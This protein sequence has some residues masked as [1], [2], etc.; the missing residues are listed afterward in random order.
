MTAP[1]V[2]IVTGAARGIGA[3][4]A[5]AL[6]AAGFELVLVDA[7][8]DDERLGYPLATE[9][10]LQAVADEVGAHTVV[11]DAADNAVL[12][13]AVEAA[14]RA[15]QLTAAVAA[16]GVISGE[17]AAWDV[18]DD[19]WTVLHETNV[20]AVQRL[21]SATI[22]TML[23]H[24]EPRSGRFIAIGSPI[25]HKATPR[26]A[27]YAASKAAAESY[28]R[29]LAADLA[30]TG[31]T[32]NTVL[33][34]STNTALLDHSAT[35]YD[36]ESTDAFREHHLIDRLLDPNEVAHVIAWLCRDAS[37]A[38]TGAS[39]PVDGGFSAR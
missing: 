1:T 12:T 7:V 31:I 6:A 36:L 26:L 9:A 34:G 20:L 33:P 23:D 4:T 3:A 37:S 14:C 11:G 17:G 38:I 32:A 16:A 22:P 13:S 39:I 19:A 27:A 10:D 25:A 28:V 2:A 30:A 29:S 21:A 35:V 8:R 5:R 15:G 24:P 18:N